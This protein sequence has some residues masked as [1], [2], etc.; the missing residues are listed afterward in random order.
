M[1]D[2]LESKAVILS[3]PDWHHRFQIQAHWTKDIRNYLYRRAGLHT[4]RRVVEVGCGTGVLLEELS[5]HSHVVIH[6][7]DINPGY[8]NLAKHNSPGAYLTL[9]DAHCLPYING[10]FEMAVCH[11][12]LLWVENPQHVISEM[13]RVTRSGGA[14]LALAE[15]DYGGLIDYPPE[16]AILGELQQESLRR[17]GANPQTG[18]RLGEI[19][20][21]ADLRSIE[22]GVLGGQWSSPLSQEERDSEWAVLESDLE[23][24]IPGTELERLRSLDTLAWESQERILYVPTFY[25]W[26]RVPS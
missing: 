6:G 13:M 24:A 17:Q 20:N 3:P 14:V 4:A 15:P 10:I 1:G 9:G 11:F 5:S 8:L 23:G 22:V 12:L 18:R 25:A 21:K 16:L 26:G 19:F 2:N 7:L